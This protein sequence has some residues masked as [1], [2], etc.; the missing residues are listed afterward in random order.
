MSSS[1]RNAVFSDFA[2]GTGKIV[3]TMTLSAEDR[4]TTAQDEASRA[5][6]G[7]DRVSSTPG[8][9]VAPGGVVLIIR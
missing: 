7:L 8:I 4:A 3:S 9:S 5:R 1:S 2:R 6:R